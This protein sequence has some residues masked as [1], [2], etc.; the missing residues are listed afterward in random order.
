MIAVMFLVSSSLS[1]KANLIPS[2]LL[3]QHLQVMSS[4]KFI[5]K[6][7]GV[8]FCV[9]ARA[10]SYTV[11]QCAFL[12]CMLARGFWCVVPFP[13]QTAKLT[14]IESA[15]ENFTLFQLNIICIPRCGSVLLHDGIF[16]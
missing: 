11:Q 9:W 15:E 5:W 8:Q 10:V 16:W 1:L 14:R 2:N 6:L 3:W 4:V 12:Q 7:C 13:L